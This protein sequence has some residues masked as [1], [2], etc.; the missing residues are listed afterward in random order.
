MGNEDFVLGLDL[1]GVCADFYDHMRQM[2]AI[3]RGVDADSLDPNVAYGLKDWGVLSGEYT[4][5]H[6]WAVTQEDFFLNVSPID[7][8]IQ[9]TR[10]LATEGVRIR[11]IT[12]RLFVDY[13]HEKAVAQTV[14]WL[15][16][17]AIPYRD[18]CFSEDKTAVRADLYVEDTPDNITALERVGPVIAFTNSTNR[19]M[20]PAPKLRANSWPEA[21]QLIRDRYYAWRELQ[22]LPLP[23]APGHAPPS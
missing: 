9:S 22:D 7:G 8:A 1:D 21:E 5:I 2:V 13:F 23:D 10:R 19:D 3:W 12:H 20:S 14:K 17:H 4:R 11:I 16:R 18:L 6:R 15:D